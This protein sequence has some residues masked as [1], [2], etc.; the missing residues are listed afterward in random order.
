MLALAA[1]GNSTAGTFFGDPSLETI[2]VKCTKKHY[3][4]PHPMHDLKDLLEGSAFQRLWVANLSPD[5]PNRSVWLV[6]P[7]P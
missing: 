1:R 7:K 4:T 5:L 3:E 6:H 2:R